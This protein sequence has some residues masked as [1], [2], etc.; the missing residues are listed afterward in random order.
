MSDGK[1]VK[2]RGAMGGYSKK[3]VNRYIEQIALILRAERKN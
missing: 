2:F 3:D 1:M